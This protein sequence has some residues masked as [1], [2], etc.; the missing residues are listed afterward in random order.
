M[1]FKARRII[2]KKKQ[3]KKKPPININRM[4]DLI[5]P[6][7]Q[8]RFDVG[9]NIM[10]TVSPILNNGI[11][12][13]NIDLTSINR[14][15]FLNN[16]EGGAIKIKGVSISLMASNSSTKTRALRFV[17]VTPIDNLHADPALATFYANA[18]Y[19]HAGLPFNK[20]S[21]SIN[22]PINRQDYKIHC[23]KV[24]N[25]KSDIGSTSGVNRKI[26]CPLKDH[27]VTYAQDGT[28]VLTGRLF[29]YVLLC[30][31]DDN[32]DAALAVVRTFSTVYFRDAHYGFGARGN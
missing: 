22:N 17:L 11:T 4:R 1:P 30:E 19:A 15:D 31:Y 18:N 23:D 16:R 14:G 6:A 28:I 29:L 26:W 5:N 10:E 2:R 7:K 20:L 25:L 12:Y 13:L 9:S 32:T 24:I 3:F 27:R 8:T 21:R